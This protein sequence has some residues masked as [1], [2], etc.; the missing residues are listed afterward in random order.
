MNTDE[1]QKTISIKGRKIVNVFPGP[2]PLS[3][4]V[5][6]IPK[7]VDVQ[8]ELFMKDEIGSEQVSEDDVDNFISRVMDTKLPSN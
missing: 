1:I 5:A 7:A 6:H 2:T 4:V 3:L 8:F